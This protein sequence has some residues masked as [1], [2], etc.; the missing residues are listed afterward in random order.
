MVAIHYLP[1]TLL[2]VL[3]SQ[4]GGNRCDYTG[5]ARSCHPPMAVAGD[6]T[7]SRTSSF[8]ENSPVVPFAI[9]VIHSAFRH[10]RFLVTGCA[11][12][13]NASMKGI[14]SKTVD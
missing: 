4:P 8:L 12:D 11:H 3:W 10:L 5:L 14:G 9:L 13:R 7:S 2:G 6:A 1:L